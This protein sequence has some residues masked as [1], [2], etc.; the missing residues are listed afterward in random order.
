[1][2]RWRFEWRE[3]SVGHAAVKHVGVSNP[4]PGGR[5]T[6]K[7]GLSSWPYVLIARAFLSTVLTGKHKKRYHCL[8]HIC[9]HHLRLHFPKTHIRT[10][11]RNIWKKHFETHINTITC[12]GTA[13]LNVIQILSQTLVHYCII[14]LFSI[15]SHNTFSVL[16]NWHWWW[17]SL[18]LLDIILFWGS[19]SYISGMECIRSGWFHGCLQQTFE[20]K[21]AV[22]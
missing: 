18:M 7:T 5:T 3:S 2:L 14:P 19:G 12:K 11:H 21:C 1:M 17:C 10:I 4:L 13:G 8:K 9:S 15:L 16:L 6:F 22:N 20:G